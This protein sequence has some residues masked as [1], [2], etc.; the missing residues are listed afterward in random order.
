MRRFT[1]GSAMV[2]ALLL[3]LTAIA[4][5]AP[6][7]CAELPFDH[8]H[9]CG[10]P[11][12]ELDP[13][14]PNY[15]DT[16]TT[17]TTTTTTSPVPDPSTLEP[18]PAE[19]VI[20]VLKPGPVSYECL[21]TPEEPALISAEGV[22][23]GIV[24]V[25]PTTEGVSSLVVFVRDDAPGDICLGAYGIDVDDQISTDGRFEGSFDLSYGSVEDIVE[26]AGWD[27][28]D[29]P[30]DE[31]P[32]SFD[33]YV[34]QDYWSFDRYDVPGETGTHWCYPQDGIASM[35]TDLNGPPLHLWVRFKAKQDAGP[36][37]VTLSVES[38]TPNS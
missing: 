36:V 26:V 9:Y 35:R 6:P 27:P 5:A 14:D 11:C 3:M 13:S 21:W 29:Y 1:I 31:R 23:E 2:L 8:P 17:T 4:T 24:T 19:K 15:C 20:E 12:D 7:N 18:C 32:P 22:V 38:K 10:P 28:L 16:P 33:P 34:D 30:E 25:T 37:A